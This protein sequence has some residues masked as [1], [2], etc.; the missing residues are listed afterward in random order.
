MINF[1]CIACAHLLQ[2]KEY[3]A[4]CQVQCPHCK[5]Q[6]TTPDAD[7]ALPRNRSEDTV[8]MPLDLSSRALPEPPQ[9]SPLDDAPRRPKGE[10]MV[11]IPGLLEGASAAQAIPVSLA[12]TAPP[13]SKPSWMENS[14]I[15]SPKMPAT[16]PVPPRLPAELAAQPDQPETSGKALGSL[17]LGLCTFLVPVLCAIPAFLLGMLALADIR[18]K[19]GLLEGRGIAYA[20]LALAV[21]GNV[22]LIPAWMLKSS[23]DQARDEKRA[24]RNLEEIGKALLRYEMEKG[25]L[26]LAGMKN[27]K[28]ELTL[29]WRVAILPHLGKKDL[30]DQ[31]RFNETWDSPHNKTL[32]TRMPSIFATNSQFGER[33]GSSTHIQ[34]ITGPDTFFP[35]G[36]A[37]TTHGVANREH[38]F[39]VVEGRDPVPWTKPEDLAYRGAAGLPKFGA[40]STEG[41]YA[42]TID[43]IVRFID[44]RVEKG[45][46]HAAI[47]PR[48][49]G[50][51]RFEIGPDRGR[52]GVDIPPGGFDR[53]IDPWDFKDAVPRDKIK[54]W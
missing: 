6:L 18:R 35:E 37:G 11:A 39:L 52:M 33:D 40:S 47:N 15:D 44:Q 50:F 48:D 49:A 29:S 19:R 21:L 1:T 43:G 12:S 31:F 45:M 17:I 14:W 5:A 27:E 42:M 41:F 46:L 53:P 9:L 26:P 24:K 34:V 7:G 13:D 22:S 32:L 2:I 23:F 36:V 16:L 54:V 25:T 20:G 51:V 38:K 4:G 28:G 30:Y 3:F 10:P 8:A